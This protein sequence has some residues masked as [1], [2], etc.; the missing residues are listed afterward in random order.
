MCCG[1]G[2]EK[3]K[4]KKRRD[5][6]RREKKKRKEKQHLWAVESGLPCSHILDGVVFLYHLDYSPGPFKTILS[7]D[8]Y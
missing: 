5:E 3:K 1:F 4:E 7:K 8:E 2:P 6:K